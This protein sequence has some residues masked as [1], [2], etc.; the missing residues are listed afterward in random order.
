MSLVRHTSARDSLPKQAAHTKSFVRKVRCLPVHL[1]Q[2]FCPRNSWLQFT[3]S[4][5]CVC[6]RVYCACECVCVCVCMCVC[7]WDSCSALKCSI[8]THLLLHCT[9]SH[10][11]LPGPLSCRPA[12]CRQSIRASIHPS[13]SDR[14]TIHP[15]IHLRSIPV[16]MRSSS[17]ASLCFRTLFSVLLPFFHRMQ[18]ISCTSW[19]PS[20]AGVSFSRPNSLFLWLLSSSSSSSSSY[21]LA[22]ALCS[23]PLFIRSLFVCPRPRL[24]L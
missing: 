22:H 12:F 6:V 15:S 17:H 10:A 11:A 24:H 1:P 4:G 20:R 23:T 5:V 8:F 9:P 19:N 3:T 13:P 7:V 2:P 16:T 21:P 14:P 18:R